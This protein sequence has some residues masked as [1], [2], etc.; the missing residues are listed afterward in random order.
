MLEVLIIMPRH[1]IIL[2]PSLERQFAHLGEKIRLARLRRRY[3]AAMVA[4]RANIARNT[5]RGIER[6]DP[7]VTM[8]AYASVLFTLGLESGLDL[9]ASDD[10]LG[11]ML[12]DA[13]LP[14]RARAPR[15]QKI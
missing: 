15:P 14:T 10:I 8:G 6:G 5:L 12:Q 3:T 9:I 4:Q 13:N 2:S 7:N 1:K 11:R